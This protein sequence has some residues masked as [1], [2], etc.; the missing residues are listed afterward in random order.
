LDLYVVGEG[1]QKLAEEARRQEVL[2]KIREAVDS[3]RFIS[4]PARENRV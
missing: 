3:E 2:L 4:S 1:K